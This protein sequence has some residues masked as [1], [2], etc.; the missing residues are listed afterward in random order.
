MGKTKQVLLSTD[1]IFIFLLTYGLSITLAAFFLASPEKLISGMEQ[2]VRSPSNLITDYVHIA[3]VGAAFLNSGLV[4]LSSLFLLRKHKHHF[5]S[6]TVSVIMMLSG[7]SF[8]GKNIVNSA[9]IILGCLIY[10]RIHHS[11][12]QDLLVMGL[13]STCLSP[14][15][16]TIYC[17]PDHSAISNKFIALVAGL[18]IGYTILPIFEF[19]KVHTK[20]LNLYNMG[21]S[22]GFIGVI[23]NLTTRNILA[24]KIVPHA[25]SFE[26]HHALLI[27]LAALFTLPF[28]VF[29]YFYKKNI[30]RSKHL[31]LDLKKIARFSLY[32]YLAVIFTL[33]LKVPLSGILVGAILTFAGFSMYN[34][35]FR[36]FF[37]P[38]L[39]VFLTALL[40]YRDAATTNNIVIILFASTLSP[41]TR[42]YGLVTGT[43][44]G[45]LFSLITRN[46]QY[47]TAGIN[48]YNCGFAGGITVLLM[49]FVR[50]SFYRN[51][52]IKAYCQNAHL[53]IIQF[54]KDL[55]TRFQVFTQS[56]LFK[57]TTMKDNQS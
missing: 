23:G 52:K 22:A 25:L 38:A 42:K 12:R 50:V 35:K 1:I 36:Y 48:L 21:F 7:F 13:L 57:I 2:I 10:L 34:F 43:L 56:F 55:L 54:E 32:G 31:F 51:T 20:E 6:L 37:F 15:V 30:D 46:T 29:L 5:C 11:G 17:A 24:I 28:L 39:G 18:L 16:S 19:L 4:T 47:L 44:S 49:D 41:M 14:I 53:R 45:A 9:P 8:F 40:L 27:F 26:H 33:L 3:G